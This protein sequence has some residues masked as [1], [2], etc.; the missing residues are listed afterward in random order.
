MGEALSDEKFQEG[1]SGTAVWRRPGRQWGRDYWR[2]SI[3]SNSRDPFDEW[4]G[5]SAVLPPV[6]LPQPSGFTM[7]L[8]VRRGSYPWA[9]EPRLDA[10]RHDCGQTE[11][12]PIL[13]GEPRSRNDVS[14]RPNQGS[15]AEPELGASD[16]TEIAVHKKRV[17]IPRLL[18]ALPTCAKRS[19]L[20]LAKIGALM[21]VN[22]LERSPKQIS[23]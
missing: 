22:L 6:Y 1:E 15:C 3:F 17:G 9:F 21:A 16:L 13:S 11:Q 10:N 20:S 19:G 8:L 2:M 7:R 4:I 23:G 18:A 5:R 14:S 12:A